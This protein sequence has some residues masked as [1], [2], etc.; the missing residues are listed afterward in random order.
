MP[1]VLTAAFVSTA[2]CSLLVST[3]G[4]AGPDGPSG[5]GG[6][7]GGND[8]RV[9]PE[10][11][12]EAGAADAGACDSGF[13]ACAADAH[14]FCD[15]FD[16]VPTGAAWTT[17]HSPGGTLAYEENGTFSPPRS[18]L[19]T[20]D[21]RMSGDA[22]ESIDLIPTPPVTRLRAEFDMAIEQSDSVSGNNA[23]AFC[24]VRLLLEPGD[25]EVRLNIYATHAD[26]E[27][28]LGTAT[29]AD[30]AV[31]VPTGTGARA[32]YGLWIDT[33]AR[34]CG[35]TVNGVEKA[36]GCALIAGITGGPASV[37]LGIL[38]VR[39]PTNAWKVRVDDVTLD[40]E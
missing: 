8:A 23:H 30:Q 26:I 21:A 18:L 19:A 29:M 3:S 28:L 27:Q 39:S 5:E 1:A 36:A 24:P 37:Q 38:F 13:C 9:T 11:S 6:G 14:S 20:T 2:A 33:K 10:A 25:Q 17:T 7:G 40:Y 34:T 32:R 16:D 4:L 31:A 12:A 35:V 15:D 22:R